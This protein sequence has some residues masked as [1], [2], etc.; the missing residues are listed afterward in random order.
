MGTAG[1]SGQSSLS[2]L[3]N[4]GLAAGWA[5]IFSVLSTQP[6]Y[7]ANLDRVHPIDIKSLPKWFSFSALLSPAILSDLP[8]ITRH[9]SPLHSTFVVCLALNEECRAM[10]RG[11]F[12]HLP[13]ETRQLSRPCDL[14][15]VDENCGLRSTTAWD[16]SDWQQRLDMFLAGKGPHTSPMTSADR[17]S[18]EDVCW[19]ASRP[20]LH[21]HSQIR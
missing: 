2:K 18:Q 1:S 14:V 8:I 15:F 10:R 20:C 13:V 17:H 5:E 9:G 11:G 12:Y 6:S 19:R 21:S 16:Q 7:E 3:S 4:L